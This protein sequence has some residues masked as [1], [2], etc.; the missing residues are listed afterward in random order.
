MQTPR[1]DPIFPS[2]CRAGRLPTSNST[3]TE[4]TKKEHML[5]EILAAL[6]NTS[7][8]LKSVRCEGYTKELCLDTR[9]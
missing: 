5:L 4:D 9:T 2:C 1:A 7:T 8:F 3:T 6:R